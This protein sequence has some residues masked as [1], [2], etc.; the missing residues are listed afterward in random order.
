MKHIWKIIAIRITLVIVSLAVYGCVIDAQKNSWGSF[1][2]RK[3]ESYDGKYYA[4]QT[5][6]EKAMLVIAIIGLIIDALNLF[7]FFL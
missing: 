4:T 2:S 5:K 7:K 3:T 6:Y 1:T